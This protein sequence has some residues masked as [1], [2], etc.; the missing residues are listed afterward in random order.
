M[1]FPF[2]NA[3][4]SS[5]A[6]LDVEAHVFVSLVMGGVQF[7]DELATLHTGVLS[8]RTWQRF[9]GFSKLL[10]SILL[11]AGAGLGH[12]NKVMFLLSEKKLQRTR[13]NSGARARLTLPTS[14]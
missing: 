10:D 13:V 6:H 8:K 12:E 11:Q 4:S 5:R 2:L 3:S 9:Q 7:R 14:P 1:P